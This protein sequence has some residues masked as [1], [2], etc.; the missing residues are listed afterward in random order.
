M[1]NEIRL[2]VAKVEILVLVLWSAW[3]EIL[4]LS[5]L[6]DALSELCACTCMCVIPTCNPGGCL[7]S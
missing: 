1:N 6:V 4:S 3:W 5:Q 2:I 7:D